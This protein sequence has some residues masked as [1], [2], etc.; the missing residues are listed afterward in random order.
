MSYTAFGAQMPEQK[1]AWVKE[2]NKAFRENFF[3]QKFTGTGPNNII[4]LVTDLKKT[5]KGTRAGIGL[6]QDLDTAGGIVGD[7]DVDGRMQSLESEW[8]EIHIDQLR[9]VVSSKGRVDDQNSV[10]E[11]RTEVKDKLSFWRA[12]VLEELTILTA[13][14]ISYAYNTDGSAR[15]VA[16]EDPLTS[17]TFAADVTTPTSNRHFNFTSDAM[18]AGDTSTISALSVPKYGMM[19]DAMAEAKTRGIKPLMIE[20]RE[21]YVWLAHPKSFARLKRDSD[22]RNAVL[23][24]MPRS[25]NNPIFTG[26]YVTMDGLIIHTNNRVY[27]TLGLASGSKWGSGGLVDGTRSLLMGCQAIGYA[28]LY[29]EAQW[30]EETTDYGAKNSVSVGIF[31]GLLKTRFTSKFD[32][33]TVQDFGLMVINLA[34]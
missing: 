31:A 30:I 4:Q 10:F 33:N 24:G 15:T 22:F 34:L 26:A 25:D 20:G 8:V 12:K 6:V 11:F 29:K 19:V 3:F 16:P 27:N 21:H 17:L 1:K 9:K 2:S 23:T 13:S 14:G 32:S 18:A 7:N 5:E 28:D